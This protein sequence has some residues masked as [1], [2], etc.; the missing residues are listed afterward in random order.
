[1]SQKGLHHSESNNVATKI[2]T[3]FTRS[4][5]AH[6]NA[7]CPAASSPDLDQTSIQRK[8]AP[9]MPDSIERPSK[10]R[11]NAT[12]NLWT[13]GG[14]ISKTTKHIRVRKLKSLPILQQNSRQEETRDYE[15]PN[16]NERTTS[17]DGERQCADDPSCSDYNHHKSGED[18]SIGEVD[19]ADYGDKDNYD[20]GTATADTLVTLRFNQ[21]E[22]DNSD[23]VGTKNNE[24]EDQES[25]SNIVEDCYQ[26]DHDESKPSVN[27]TSPATKLFFDEDNKA[28]A[29]PIDE[30]DPDNHLAILSNLLWNLEKPKDFMDK[31]LIKYQSF[32]KKLGAE[33]IKGQILQSLEED[34]RK[35]IETGQLD[36]RTLKAC[37]TRMAQYCG[38]PGVYVH[39]MYNP[40][41]PADIGIYIGSALHVATRIKEHIRCRY[42][43]KRKSSGI[44]HWK[45]WNRPGIR[46][47]WVVLGRF[48]DDFVFKDKERLPLLL[49]ILEIYGMLLFRT[50]H[51]SLLRAYLPK[52][53]QTQ[54]YPWTGLNTANPLSQYRRGIQKSHLGQNPRR[55]KYFWQNYH[56]TRRNTL[57]MI[58]A[59]DPSK[60]DKRTVEVM[61]SVPQPA[62]ILCQ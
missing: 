54:P 49:N 38:Y 41:D 15:Y 5:R 1:M 47:F 58:R 9:S 3:Y 60:G 46:D 32:V 51:W 31:L 4:H 62:F 43:P 34:V 22:L 33:V 52:G 39:V 37:N 61:C 56:R 7:P 36:V 13:R 26:N 10:M 6:L 17:N 44:E 8:R 20:E 55:H 12:S 24:C 21:E 45:F 19:N 27:K 48:K 53:S 28:L 30:L 35:M 18:E 23:E 50:P 25:D 57:F 59:A 2:N 14:R 29:D 11:R 42:N 16:K 40:N